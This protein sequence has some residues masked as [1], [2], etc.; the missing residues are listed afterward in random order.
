VSHQIL[1]NEYGKVRVFQ[2]GF[3]LETDIGTPTDYAR[4]EQALGAKIVNARDVQIVSEDA[5]HE[6]GLAQ[7]LMMGHG[8]ANDDIAPQSQM[9][10]ALSGSFAII[11][12]GAFGP[13]G[14]TLQ[15]DGEAK[16]VATF[17]EEAAAPP[18]LTPLASDN[19]D[20]A[21]PPPEPTGKPPK[22][23]ARI[24]GMV[25][26]V[27]LLLMGLLVWLMIWIGG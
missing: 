16:L 18:P 8:I 26:T 10:N 4:L 3:A 2:L 15:T 5:L 24:G 20:G 22:S 9:L 21:M 27:A 6:L 12:S 11:R 1:P 25:A 23:D 7:F 19:T 13:D 17:A 14:A